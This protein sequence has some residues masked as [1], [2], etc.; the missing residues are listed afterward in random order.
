[1][2]CSHNF[3]NFFSFGQ[4]LFLWFFF[5]SVI[6]VMH[7]CSWISKEISSDWIH[8]HYRKKAKIKYSMFIKPY[9]SAS[10]W[11]ESKRKYNMYASADRLAILVD[12][13]S[14]LSF[15]TESWRARP[16]S[17]FQG[18]LVFLICGAQ[19][20]LLCNFPLHILNHHHWMYLVKDQI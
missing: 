1:M 3:I 16:I 20:L 5:F 13:C 14:E 12:R 8:S 18:K 15:P 19:L 6:F 17:L 9:S 2:S 4:I 10:S 11:R 7:E